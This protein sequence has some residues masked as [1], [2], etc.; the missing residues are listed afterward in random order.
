MTTSPPPFPKFPELP[1]KP[2]G[3]QGGPA[4]VRGG[5]DSSYLWSLTGRATELGAGIIGMTLGGLLLDHFLN[6]LPWITIGGAVVG[7]LGGGYNFIRFASQQSR[8]TAAQFRAEHPGG[9]TQR[10]DNEHSPGADDPEPE[11]DNIARR[12]R[13]HREKWESDEDRRSRREAKHQTRRDGSGG[14]A[15]F[16]G[17]AAGGGGHKGKSPGPDPGAKHPD[18]AGR[19][20]IDDGGASDGGAGDGGGGGD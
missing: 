8:S 11:S 6:T 19:D 4:G 9:V 2:G 17:G 18:H 14:E 7:I 20:T 5:Q 1:P 16:F 10:S 12:D 13:A 15:A 3:R